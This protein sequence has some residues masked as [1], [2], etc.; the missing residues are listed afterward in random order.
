MNEFIRSQWAKSKRSLAA[1]EAIFETDPAQQHRG[2]TTPRFM[3]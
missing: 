3:V 1:A 2:L